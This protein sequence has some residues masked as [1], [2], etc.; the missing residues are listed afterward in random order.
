MSAA[1]SLLNF[2]RENQ[3]NTLQS[4]TIAQNQ[5][6]VNNPKPKKSKTK[7]TKTPKKPKPKKSKEPKPRKPKKPKKTLFH[8]S[9]RKAL[10]IYTN[11]RVLK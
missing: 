6:K 3:S 1:F 11:G 8:Y 2:V 9:S 10:E 7:K 4:M 5:K